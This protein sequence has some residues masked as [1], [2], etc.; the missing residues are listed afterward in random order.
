MENEFVFLQKNNTWKIIRRFIDRHVL[1][2]K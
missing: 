2:N 1:R